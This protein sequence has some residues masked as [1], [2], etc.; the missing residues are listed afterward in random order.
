MLT[1][2]LKQ[3]Q[4]LNCNHA[5]RCVCLA[6]T[7]EKKAEQFI[8]QVLLSSECRKRSNISNKSKDYTFIHHNTQSF[9][10]TTSF[11]KYPGKLKDLYT[12]PV[13][14]LPTTC[15]LHVHNENHQNKF[16]WKEDPIH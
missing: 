16:K 6:N 7:K 12:S 9:K 1:D 2:R 11:S 10:Q 14:T 4:Q 3:L 15:N 5:K 8:S 13:G